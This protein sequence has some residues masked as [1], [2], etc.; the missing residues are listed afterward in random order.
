MSPLTIEKLVTL[1]ILAVQSVRAARA[2]DPRSMPIDLM[3]RLR[4]EM[5]LLGD[6]LDS[7][8]EAELAKRRA[9]DGKSASDSE[10]AR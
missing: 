10:K 8:I 1:G 5:T 2:D 9:K 4:A 3:R 7:D 6:D